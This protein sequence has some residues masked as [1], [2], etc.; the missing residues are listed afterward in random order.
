MIYDALSKKLYV[1]DVNVLDE[2]LSCLLKC[3]TLLERDPKKSD[4]RR[5]LTKFDE[6][7]QVLLS[8]TSMFSEQELLM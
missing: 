2:T 7:F 4:H 1:R 3:L 8:N 5:N 6:T